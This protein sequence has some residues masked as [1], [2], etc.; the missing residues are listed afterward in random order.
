MPETKFCTRCQEIKPLADFYL[1][2]Q[3]GKPSASCKLCTSRAAR[4]WSKNNPERSRQFV[5]E[6]RK[7][8]LERDK[9]RQREN[10]YICRE[11]RL[12]YGKEWRQANSEKIRQTAR[13]SQAHSLARKHGAEGTFTFDQWQAICDYYGNK[14]LACGEQKPLTIDHI[15]PISKG[16]RND[17]TNIQPLCAYCN[18]SKQQKI[19]DYRPTVPEWA[20]QA[21]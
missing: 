19:I 15:V 17:I 21:N 20:K 10:Y 11:A 14:C 4:E 12:Q 3:T 5:R 18:N 1:S 7:N 8:N 13:I 16:G 9:A 2:K 6:Y